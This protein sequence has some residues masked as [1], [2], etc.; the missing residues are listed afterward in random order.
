MEGDGQ[1]L[2]VS[3]GLSRAAHMKRQAQGL[4]GPEAKC[5]Q[6]WDERTRV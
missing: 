4:D 2:P 5:D 6:H 3:T 1:P